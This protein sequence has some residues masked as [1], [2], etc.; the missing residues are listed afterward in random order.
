MK[1]FHIADENN[2]PQKATTLLENKNFKGMKTDNQPHNASK[3]ELPSVDLG[4][5]HLPHTSLPN[6]TCR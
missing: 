4:F 6:T 1:I 5:G 3:K 2:L